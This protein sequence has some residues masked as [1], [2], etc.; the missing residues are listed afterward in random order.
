MK[1]AFG[2]TSYATLYNRRPFDFMSAHAIFIYMWW[3]VT[4]CATLQDL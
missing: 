3:G 1:S 2:C 4:K